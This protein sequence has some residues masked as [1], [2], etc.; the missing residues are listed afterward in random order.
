MW[1]NS[2]PK[3]GL[4]LLTALFLPFVSTLIHAAE[5]D[6]LQDSLWEGDIPQQASRQERTAEEQRRYARWLE[7]ENPTKALEL[8]DKALAL[9]KTPGQREALQLGRA[10]SLYRL[11]RYLEAFA[12][13]EASFPAQEPPVDALLERCA[14]EIQIGTALLA[15]GKDPAGQTTEEEKSASGYAA[16]SRVFAATLYNDPRGAKVPQALL[17]LGDAEAGRGRTEA[18]TGAYLQLV[19]RVPQHPLADVA[20]IRASRL[21]AAAASHA[22]DDDRL[23]RAQALLADLRHPPEALEAPV[24]EEWEEAQKALHEGAAGVMVR[25]AQYYLGGNNRRAQK[26]GVFLLREVMQRFPDTRAANEAAAALKQ[27]G[28]APATKPQDQGEE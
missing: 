28:L 5:G 27:R 12:A 23:A 19:S 8:Y 18:A 26:S 10:R 4:I 2:L 14:L 21:L 3:S 6:L 24:R 22:G 9:S 17:G 13:V 15:R 20:R 16:A 1:R 11:Q 25:K 7:Q